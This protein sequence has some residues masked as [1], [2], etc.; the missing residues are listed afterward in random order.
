MNRPDQHRLT[1]IVSEVLDLIDS[2]NIFE[3]LGGDDCK[4]PEKLEALF[5]RLLSTRQ[6][7]HPLELAMYLRT[8]YTRSKH[9]PSWQPL[10]NAAFEM[11]K[12]QGLDAEGMFHGLMPKAAHPQRNTGQI[13][14]QQ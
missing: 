12:M 3:F 5:Q 7:Y 2:P 6:Q 8:A 9:C 13:T 1:E 14:Q 4:Y 11:A 10:L